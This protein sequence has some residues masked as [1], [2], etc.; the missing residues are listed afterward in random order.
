MGGGVIG[1]PLF[2]SNIRTLHAI[3]I[4]ILNGMLLS[5]CLHSGVLYGVLVAVAVLTI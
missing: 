5:D 1:V 2:L 4:N 3:F